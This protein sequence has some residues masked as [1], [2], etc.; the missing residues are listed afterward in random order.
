MSVVRPV[1]RQ[2]Q[3]HAAWLPWRSSAL[4][5][6][7]HR[8]RASRRA[9]GVERRQENTRGRGARQLG[10][11]SGSHSL[12][13]ASAQ[14]LRRKKKNRQSSRRAPTRW[15]NSGASQGTG[16]PLGGVGAWRGPLV[17]RASVQ[18]VVLANGFEERLLVTC[19]SGLKQ[20]LTLGWRLG[21]LGDWRKILKSS[22]FH[23]LRL[24]TAA[25]FFFTRSHP[26]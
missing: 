5:F 3:T 10:S 8:V 25:I 22:F 1:Q 13:P 9:T 12:A 24:R 21:V 6:A 11:E 14:V 26:F 17:P 19:A 15:R 20:L 2:L 18:P 7:I 4:F 16:G 23:S